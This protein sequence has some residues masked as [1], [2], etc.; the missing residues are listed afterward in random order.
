MPLLL[1]VLLPDVFHRVLAFLR[2]DDAELKAAP[3]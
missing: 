3:P 1:S 2:L